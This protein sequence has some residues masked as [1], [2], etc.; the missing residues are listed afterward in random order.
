MIMEALSAPAGLTCWNTLGF[1]F[2]DY[3]GD[4]MMEGD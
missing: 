2:A 3:S 1:C 4:A